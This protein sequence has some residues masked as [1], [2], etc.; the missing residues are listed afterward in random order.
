[1]QTRLIKTNHQIAILFS[2]G[3]IFMFLLTNIDPSVARA[4]G[5]GIPTLTPTVTR[6]VGPTPPTISPTA[7]FT[8]LAPYPFE[9]SG[10]SSGANQPMLQ[11]VVSTPTFQPVPP[12]VESGF[13]LSGCLPTGIIVLLAGILLL[14]FFFARRTR[15]KPQ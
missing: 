8:S 15:K 1:M 12:P 14:T 6:T 11:Q 3:L 10:E 7:T 13:S 2:I 5:G 4:D 9:S